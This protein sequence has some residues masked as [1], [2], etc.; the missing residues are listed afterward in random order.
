MI[1]EIHCI[2]N[3][4]KTAK[5]EWENDDSWLSSSFIQCKKLRQFFFHTYSLTCIKKDTLVLLKVV[6]IRTIS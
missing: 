2:T 3:K 6:N 5:N 1:E 4:E